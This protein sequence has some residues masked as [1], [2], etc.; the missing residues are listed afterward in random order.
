MVQR[1]LGKHIVG[2]SAAPRRHARQNDRMRRDV[3]DGEVVEELEGVAGGAAL[4]GVD[5]VVAIRHRRV[6]V[7]YRQR[8]HLDPGTGPRVGRPEQKCADRHQRSR[9]VP[10]SNNDHRL[11]THTRLVA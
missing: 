4:P 5:Q 1:T 11:V 6:R 9:H 3:V 2:G 8:E 10:E 7:S